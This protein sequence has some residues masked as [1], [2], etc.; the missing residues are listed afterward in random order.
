MRVCVRAC[1]Q[2]S[3]IIQCMCI[4]LELLRSVLFWTWVQLL[5]YLLIFFFQKVVSFD[6]Y[7]SINIRHCS[8]Y[9]IN[10]V[11]TVHTDEVLL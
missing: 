5:N 3:Y 9:Q 7:V 6:L 2:S 8:N 1:A 10:R 11:V 4:L